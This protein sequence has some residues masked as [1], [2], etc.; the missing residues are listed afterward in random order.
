M[1]LVTILLERVLRESLGAQGLVGETL[2]GDYC[3]ITDVAEAV[4]GGLPVRAG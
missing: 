4:S 3:G 1:W 2:Q